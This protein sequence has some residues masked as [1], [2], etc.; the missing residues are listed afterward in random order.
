MI[1]ASSIGIGVGRVMAGSLGVS[2]DRSVD[3]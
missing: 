1:S 2:V 3:R